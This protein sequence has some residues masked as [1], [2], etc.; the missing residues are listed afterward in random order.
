[1]KIHNFIYCTAL[2]AL[3]ALTPAA[4]AAEYTFRYG[5]SQP[6]EAPRSQSMIFFKKDMEKV[7]GGRIKVENYFGAVLGNE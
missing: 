1:M 4:Q 3:I 7:S 2:A 6:E 5:N